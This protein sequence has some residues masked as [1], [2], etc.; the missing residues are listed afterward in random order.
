[1]TAF[2]VSPICAQIARF[3][4]F[5]MRAVAYIR[6]MTISCAYDTQNPALTT[7]EGGYVHF[8]CI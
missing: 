5:K 1:M 8:A 7:A 4:T 2:P 3:D 6:Q